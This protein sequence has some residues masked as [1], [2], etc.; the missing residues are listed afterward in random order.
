[1]AV[2]SKCGRTL[3]FLAPG[4]TIRFKEYCSECAKSIP[5]CDKCKY[6]YRS[7]VH[8][9]YGCCAYFNQYLQ[10]YDNVCDAYATGRQ[11]HDDVTV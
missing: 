10:D 7:D 2:C 1:M 11:V 9:R 3:G 6:H 8:P 4:R 5:S